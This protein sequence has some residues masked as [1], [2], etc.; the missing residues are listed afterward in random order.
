MN[1]NSLEKIVTQ[2][3]RCP[4]LVA[5]RERVPKRKAFENESYWRKPLPGF[6]DPQ[7]PLLILG[8]APS[9]HGGNRTGRIFT[10]D[11]SGAF[12]VKALYKAGFASQPSSL[13]KADGLA[14]HRCYLTAAVKCVPPENRPTTEEFVNCSDYLATEMLLLKQLK[15]VLVLGQLAF[16]H[17]L[18]F[19][20]RNHIEARATFEHGKK[21]QFPQAPTIWASY[22]PSPQNTNTG[23][24]TERMFLH[25]LQEIKKEIL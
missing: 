11:G 24:L 3:R 7:A 8:L 17:F 13:S 12:L 1:F 23:K 6:G 22:H 9:A 25:L 16:D 2:C 4:R 14:L 10:G 19:L 15:G 21:Y 18:R 20:Q 5:F